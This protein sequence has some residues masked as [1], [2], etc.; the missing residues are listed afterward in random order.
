MNISILSYKRL[1]DNGIPDSP[2][3]E[4]KGI[5]P[6]ENTNNTAEEVLE[7][8]NSEEYIDSLIEEY[9][10]ITDEVKNEEI[11]YSLE[12]YILPDPF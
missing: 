11:Y 4:E 2:V 6:A 8:V 7:L 9:W 3:T 5:V 1:I 12:G 10:F